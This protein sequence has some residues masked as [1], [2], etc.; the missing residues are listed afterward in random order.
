[1]K[2]LQTAT[3]TNPPNLKCAP[4]RSAQDLKQGE[5]VQCRYG[6]EG[7]H[8][9][10]KIVAVTTSSMGVNYYNVEFMEDNIGEASEASEP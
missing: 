4:L 6:N 8:Y 2:W 1:M 5:T 9:S 3:S 7:A 10:A